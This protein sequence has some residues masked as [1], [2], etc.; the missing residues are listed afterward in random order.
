MKNNP[1][2]HIEKQSEI[3]IKCSPKDLKR[4]H[5]IVTAMSKLF[6]YKP[7]SSRVFAEDILPITED[8]LECVKDLK[9]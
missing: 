7:S 2:T 5:K 6:C 3:H 1:K 9:D 8:F 4:W